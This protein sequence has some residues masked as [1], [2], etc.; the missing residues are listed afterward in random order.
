MEAGS[1]NSSFD[2]DRIQNRP[3]GR[4]LDFSYTDNTRG[5]LMVPLLSS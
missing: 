4:F 3:L 2:F 1:R 5:F